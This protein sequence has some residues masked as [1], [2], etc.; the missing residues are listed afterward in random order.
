[1]QSVKTDEPTKAW[2]ARLFQDSDRASLLKLSAAHFGEREPGTAAYFDWLSKGAPAGKTLIPVCEAQPSGEIVGFAFYI[3]F[4]V[5]FEGRIE[6]CYLGCNALV[7]PDYRRLGI[8]SA[9][10]DIIRVELADGIFQYGFPKP[11]A[12]LPHAKVGKRPVSRIPLLIRPLQIGRLA[13]ARFDSPL[14]RRGI[15]FG[16]WFAGNLL[17]RPQR[18]RL[19]SG[20]ELR[21]FEDF[22]E[23]FDRFW[24][25]VEGKYEIAILRNQSFLRWRFRDPAFRSYDILAVAE[26]DEL[27]GYAVTR[28]TQIQGVDTGLIMD[29]LVEP[30]PRG[31]RAG[32]ALVEEATRRFAASGMAMAGCLMLPHTQEFQILRR[33]GYVEPP[34][35]FAP[36]QFRLNTVSLSPEITGESLRQGKRWFITM[37][38]HDAV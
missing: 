13:R 25:R 33:A 31:D 8:Y 20:M 3:P 7:H 28:A 5:T 26:G 37:A 2:R 30:G 16:W 10:T 27:V 38:N 14:L 6:R 35:R 4:E 1:M 19:D 22:D 24:Q 9:F 17:W 32:L 12:L 21:A 34:P 23:R 18:A 36:Q 29:L 15:E 11:E